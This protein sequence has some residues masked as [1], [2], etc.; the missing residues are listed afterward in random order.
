MIKTLYHYIFHEL[1]ITFL[2]TISILLS[3]FFAQQILRLSRLSA[4]TGISLIDLLKL[5]P[6]IMPLF[7]VLAI[8]LS[9]L[10]TSILTFSRLS[11][12]L[13]ITAIKSAGISTYRLLTPV[14]IFSSTIFVI[15]LLSSL[16]FQ[17]L[18]GNYI[19][20]EASRIIGGY[21]GLKL[22]EGVFNN[23]F[24]LLIYTKK[25][26]DSSLEGLFIS[27]RIPSKPQIITARRGHLLKD[28][29][30]DLFL[31]LEDG[32]IHFESENRDE[33]QMATFS[34]YYLKIDTGKSVENI[35]L[36][37]EVWGMSPGEVRARLEEEKR[38]G[39]VR[40]Y[41]R[42]LLEYHKKFSIPVSVLILGV[43]GV[44]LGIRTRFSSKLAGFLVSVLIIFAY[45]VVDTGF[46]IL[47]V[48]GGINPVWAAWI[49]DGLAAIL[50]IYAV[51][52]G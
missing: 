20:K 31:K 51:R 1:F 45:Y 12:D 37:K 15:A 38:A 21:K 50:T 14:I 23:L 3:A 16:M 18:A 42:L 4:E 41:R 19:K 36:F 49:P 10:L 5:I 43:L 48:E 52:K 32:S 7:S 28:R 35:R 44:P 29:A 17:P 27:E 6:F 33:Y 34:T 9:I 11:T 30:G 25:V 24:N 8:P 26:K 39:R 22:S 46:E 47:A 13:E 40:N 2:L